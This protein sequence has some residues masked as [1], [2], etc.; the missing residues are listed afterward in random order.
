LELDYSCL[1]YYINYLEGTNTARYL[2]VKESNGNLLE[3]NPKNNAAPSNLAEWRIIPEELLDTLVLIAQ[4][5]LHGNG[6]EGIS[7]QNTVITTETEWENLQTA[8]NTVNNVTDGF[9]ETDIDFSKY[10]I[11][12]VFDEIRP[13]GGWTIDITDITE[14]TDSI[15]VSYT[16]LEIGNGTKVITQPF[17]IVKIPKSNKM[18]VF[19][20]EGDVPYIPCPCGEE[21]FEE[22][23]F[24][25][26]EAYLFKDS[27]P[28]QMYNQIQAELSDKSHV[29]CWILIQKGMVTMTIGN[30][31]KILLVYGIIC[32]FPNYAKKWSIPQNGYKVDVKGLLYTS[33]GGTT[34]HIGLDYLLTKIE[35][36]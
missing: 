21:P 8:M 15:V 31:N 35:R 24:P 11:I 34:G 7:K 17:Y 26:G 36:K 4:G 5:V 16:N 10:Q 9:A 18:I 29:V 6:Q 33:C 2:V 22:L 23:Q 30:L 14:Y 20:E 3:V 13:N 25:Q 1:I 28:L 12:A 19:Y 32:N 27:I